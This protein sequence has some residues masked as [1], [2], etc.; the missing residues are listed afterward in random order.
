MMLVIV[1]AGCDSF[2][3]YAKKGRQSEASL[4]LKKM[5]KAVKTHFNMSSILPPTSTTPMPGPDGSACGAAGGKI[6]MRPQ[7]DWAADPGWKAMEFYIDEPARFTYHW[8]STGQGAQAA[9]VGLAVG[10]LDCDTTLV[11]Y[12]LDIAIVDGNAQ[13]T[14]ADPTPD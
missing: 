3:D 7:S 10:D 2:S 12:R 5:E 4:Q 11:T 8:T 13:A 14:F 6:P 9:G 1:L